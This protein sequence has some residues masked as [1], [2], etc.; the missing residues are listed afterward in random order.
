MGPLLFLKSLDLKSWIIIALIAALVGMWTVVQFRNIK[1]SRLENSVKEKELV[2]VGYKQQVSTLSDAI[3]KQNEAVEALALRNSE[4]ESY[5]NNAN[6]QNKRVTAQ[7]DA[8]IKYIKGSLV[9]TDC[10]GAVSHL[11]EFTKEFA[12]DWNKK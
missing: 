8:L 9:P 11:N 4:F 12:K 6:N 7:A 5:L 3:T 1:V 2:I 10:S